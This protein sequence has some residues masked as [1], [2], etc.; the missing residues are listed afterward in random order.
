MGENLDV[1]GRLA[2]RTPMQWSSDEG[3]GFSRA[4]RSR[5]CRPLA[6]GSYAPQHVN[7]ADQRRD[8]D[9][10]LSFMQL[11]IRRYR[12]SPELG[13]ATFRVLEQPHHNVLA[14]VCS[15]DDGSLVAVHNLAPEAC[16]VPI[17]LEGCDDRH[18]LEDLLREETTR[19]DDKGRVTVVMEGYG[20]R[21]MRVV[22]DG[23][24]RLL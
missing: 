10:L 17:Q 2:V 11:L 3:G 15:W 18:R 4:R 23:S 8:P 22:A 9:S 6:T 7:V 19:L 24:R 13:W 16:E 5:L 14:H 20:Y 21:W 1:P 12:D